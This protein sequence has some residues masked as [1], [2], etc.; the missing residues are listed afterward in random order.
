M[1]YL[2]QFLI[3][4]AVT[5]AGELLHELIPFPVP[6]SIYGLLL[7]FALLCSGVLKLPAVE[8]AGDYLLEIMPVMFVPVNVGLMVSWGLLKP[9]LV[10][11]L[12][13]TVVSTFLVMA[14]AGHVTQ[15]MMRRSEKRGKGGG[16]HE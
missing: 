8:K 7:M 3:I 9:V 6:A 10:P 1:R 16:A 15:F 4:L 14:A 12:V 11:V 13:I 2:K 5:F